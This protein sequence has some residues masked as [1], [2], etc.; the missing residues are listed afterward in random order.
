MADN[1]LTDLEKKHQAISNITSEQHGTTKNS[2][3][4]SFED[5][6]AGLDQK[7]IEELNNKLCKPK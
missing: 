3:K 5:S 7:T 2:V 4:D 1:K 6:E